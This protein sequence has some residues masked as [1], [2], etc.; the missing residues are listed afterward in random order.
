MAKGCILFLLKLVDLAVDGRFVRVWEPRNIAISDELG[1]CSI[2]TKGS[3]MEMPGLYREVEQQVDI[4]DHKKGSESHYL[5]R[6][7]SQ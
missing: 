3:S 1:I 4:F 6:G 7:L 2:C 5:P